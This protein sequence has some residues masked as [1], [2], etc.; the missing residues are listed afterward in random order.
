MQHPSNSALLHQIL[1]CY[2]LRDNLH[3]AEGTGLTIVNRQCIKMTR[4]M[5]QIIVLLGLIQS[6]PKH[7]TFMAH[8]ENLLVV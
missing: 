6:P 5:K 3:Q 1:L 7:R 8:D 2:M 4:I